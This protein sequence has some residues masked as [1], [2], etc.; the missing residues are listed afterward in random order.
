MLSPRQ[1]P[2]ETPR[3]LELEELPV[4]IEEFVLAAKRA[5]EAGFDGVE[6]HAG[7]SHVSEAEAS[8]TSFWHLT[9]VPE[10]QPACA[11]ICA[12]NGYILQQFLAKDTNRRTDE[13]GG[14]VENRAR[15]VLEVLAHSPDFFE[16]R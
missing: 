9:H 14:S 8:C 15:F 10:C 11:P 2:Y 7:E 5:I 3:A 12:G 1:V 4:V 6:L 16:L 13:Y